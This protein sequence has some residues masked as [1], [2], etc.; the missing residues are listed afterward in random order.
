MLNDQL[1][2]S[3]VIPL[4][5]KAEFVSAAL[6][7][8]FIQTYPVHEIIIVDDGSTDDSLSVVKAISHPSIRLIQQKNVG[9]SVA[10]NVGMQVATGDFIAFLDADDRYLAD[11]FSSIIR[12]SH[13]FP[14]AELLSTAYRRFSDL[15]GVISATS[16]SEYKGARGYILDFYSEWCRTSFFST[17][18]VVIRSSALRQSGIRFPIGERLSEDQDVWF[19]FAERYPMAFDPEVHSE[20]R[21]DVA[22]SATSNERLLEIVPC[23]QRLADRIRRNE[24]PPK[25][26][27]SA[28]RLFASHLL[29][30]A[31]TRLSVG[32]IKGA[33]RLLL[34][35]M[36]SANITYFIRTSLLLSVALL[37]IGVKK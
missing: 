16:A 1:K 31:R 36:A 5:N 32:D 14:K 30:L 7:S 4:Y 17:I 25:L 2:I 35:P 11:F 29:N 15:A 20:Y 12:L 24:V 3:V 27:R 6:D 13:D 23:Y 9:V 37:G 21:V 19:Q 10:R 33:W 18:S 8:I 26:L 22:G 34:N 28:R